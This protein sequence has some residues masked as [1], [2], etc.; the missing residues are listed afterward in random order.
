MGGWRKRTIGPD[1]RPPACKLPPALQP[2]KGPR[3]SPSMPEWLSF[4]AS[5]IC[6]QLC[7]NSAD[8]NFLPLRL[9]QEHD[10]S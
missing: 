10:A 5:A 8:G 1:G 3:F 2:S 9:Q 6:G 7:C 4:V